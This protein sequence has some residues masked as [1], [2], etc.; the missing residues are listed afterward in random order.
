MSTPAL[1]PDAL[2]L[3]SYTPAGAVLSVPLVAAVVGSDELAWYVSG[4]GL[5]GR[6]RY[7]WQGATWELR[8]DGTLTAVEAKKKAA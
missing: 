8:R 3:V 5:V 2:A 4:S 1:T 7:T 6:P